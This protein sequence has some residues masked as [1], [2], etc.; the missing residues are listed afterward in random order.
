MM[1]PSAQNGKCIFLLK[2][3]FQT[4]TRL[5]IFVFVI[6]CRLCHVSCV[7]V[8]TNEFLMWAD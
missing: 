1:D 6:G 3:Y 7:C 5:V 2:S 4:K 8:T